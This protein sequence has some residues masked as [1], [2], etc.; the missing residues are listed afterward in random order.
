MAGWAYAS[1]R[2]RPRER[3]IDTVEDRRGRDTDYDR[4]E[5]RIQHEREE[6]AKTDRREGPSF[7]VNRMIIN[8]PFI[9]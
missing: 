8:S 5:R 6:D 3:E 1:H 9:S 2:K 4:K 7:S